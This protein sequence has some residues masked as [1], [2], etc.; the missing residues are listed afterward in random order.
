MELSLGLNNVLG[1]PSR[2]VTQKTMISETSVVIATRLLKLEPYRT[3]VVH[4][5]PGMYSL[6]AIC[7][8]LGNFY[9]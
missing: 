3:A 5:L 6:T 1:D 2:L 4:E 7:C 8:D 9:F